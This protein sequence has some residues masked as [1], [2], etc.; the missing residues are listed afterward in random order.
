MWLCSAP[1]GL[2]VGKG[3]RSPTLGALQGSSPPPSGSLPA[4]IP[5]P[6]AVPGAVLGQLLGAFGQESPEGAPLLCPPVTCVT[7]PGRLA[8]ALWLLLGRRGS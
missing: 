2:G 3:P 8:S 4:F 7:Y 6:P 5:L 1:L